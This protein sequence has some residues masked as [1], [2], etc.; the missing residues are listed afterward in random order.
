MAVDS[1]ESAAVAVAVAAVAL[2]AVAVALVAVAVDLAAADSTSPP[3]R[4]IRIAPPAGS[5][6]ALDV[7]DALDPPANAS[8]PVKPAVQAQTKIAASPKFELASSSAAGAASSSADAQPAAK[9]EIIT[10]K[11]DSDPDKM[12]NDYF[13]GLKDPDPSHAPEIIANR[14][15][16]VRDTAKELM[17]AH[18]FL[19]VTAL[20]NA[21]L[22]NGY[23]QPWMYEAL[24][25][26]ME[27]DNQPKADI[28][29]VLMSAVDFANSA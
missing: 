11:A 24:A 5:G 9:P 2:V 17:N 12:W 14:N 20:L 19:E 13:A 10:P 4:E 25:L 6:G 26:A 3:K 22:R 29:R 21:A 16:A 28:E 15:A 1:A 18:K 7:A 27:A 8:K 23:A